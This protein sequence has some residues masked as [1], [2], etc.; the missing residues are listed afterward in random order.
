VPPTAPLA[1]ATRQV[2]TFKPI[3][4]LIR[5]TF[6]LPVLTH[7]LMIERPDRVL[8]VV[9]LRDRPEVKAGVL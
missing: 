9:G 5:E 1:S 2:C 4:E 7:H 8:E 3:R 6:Q